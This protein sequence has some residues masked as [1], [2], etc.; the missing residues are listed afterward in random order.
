M[1]D[2]IR[3]AVLGMKHSRIRNYIAPGLTSWLVGGESRGKIR[4]FTSDRDTR[5]LITPHSHR[6]NFTCLVLRG[7][8]TNVLF[9]RTYST[10]NSYAVGKLR[11]PK[12]GIG[13][14]E[15]TPG[16]KGEYFSE[17]VTRYA[18]GDTYSM[19]CYQ[20]HTICFSRDSAVLFFEGPEITD[21]SVVLEPWSDDRRVPT[22]VT[23][24]W[25]FDRASEIG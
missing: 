9:S 4:L 1:I 5:E 19:K 21:T 17:E 12:G 3:E 13:E 15:F 23:Q 10:G 18:E 25:M 22:F 20:I 14:Y 11:A 7:H 8:V 2:A 6:F 16:E 24:P